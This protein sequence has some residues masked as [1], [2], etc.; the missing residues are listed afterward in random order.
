MT[1]Q[2]FGACAL[3]LAGTFEPAEDAD[4][5]DPVID[6]TGD[7]TADGDPV[8]DDAATDPS[9]DDGGSPQDEDA[10]EG[11]PDADLNEE[12]AFDVEIDDGEP[13]DAAE[14]PCDPASCPGHCCDDASGGA[15]CHY[16][17]CNELNEAWPGLPSGVYEI[18]TD[19][20]GPRAAFEVY[21]DM[22][23]DGGGW[24]LVGRSFG[25]IAPSDS[26]GWKSATGS[27]SVDDQAYSLN[28][29]NAGI[30][31]TEIL[32]GSYSSGKSW[33]NNA[34][35]MPVPADF[36]S[37]YSNSSYTI[38]GGPSTVIGDCVPSGGPTMLRR[39]G[40]TDN[41]SRF[42]FRDQF[43]DYP[44]GLLSIG[45]DTYYDNCDWG[46]NLNDLQGMIF[47]R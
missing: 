29:D 37:S 9:A 7:L 2:S 41:A 44:V 19:G 12:A 4:L 27:V 18:D 47:V 31:F 32:V 46:A 35:K 25:G 26:F 10:G 17:S 24:T 8:L 21:C 34:Y 28:V 1:F 39:A 43:G 45:F 40:Y 38:P 42:H 16:S 6:G 22:A 30:A 36:L 20:G 11:L 5:P 13:E 14:A 23:A 15:C 3:R 33:G